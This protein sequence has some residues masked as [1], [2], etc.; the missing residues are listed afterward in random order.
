MGYLAHLF[1]DF[2][3]HDLEVL[4]SG[5]LFELLFAHSCIVQVINKRGSVDRY[6]SV[7]DQ[8]AHKLDGHQDIP[9]A[10]VERGQVF[11]LVEVGAPVE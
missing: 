2:G 11:L 8:V 4:L 7:A 1:T 6:H 5:I 3:L 10:A 9:I